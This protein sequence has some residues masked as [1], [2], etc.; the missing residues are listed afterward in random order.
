MT[1]RLRERSA[2][3]RRSVLTPGRTFVRVALIGAILVL[4]W[5][6]G[7][8]LR[9]WLVVGVAVLWAASLPFL[10]RGLGRQL[11]GTEALVPWQRRALLFAAALV[12]LAG[13]AAGVA[14][15]LR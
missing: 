6:Q 8:S 14:V 11:D 2:A 7:Y 10:L 3:R 12:L 13:F 9:A 1:I 4:A 15:L 5:M